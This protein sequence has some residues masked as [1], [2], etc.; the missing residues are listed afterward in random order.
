VTKIAP[1]HLQLVIWTDF[2][3]HSG[4]PNIPT[5]ERAIQ[6]MTGLPGFD[7]QVSGNLDGRN[8]SKSASS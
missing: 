5:M 4:T 3:R 1:S 6:R 7:H 2:Q 8:G